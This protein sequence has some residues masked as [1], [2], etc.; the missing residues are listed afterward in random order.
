MPGFTTAS[1]Q[2]SKS[3]K[4]GKYGNWQSGLTYVLLLVIWEGLGRLYPP[5]ILP[6]PWETVQTLYRL[7]EQGPWASRCFTRF[8]GSP[9]GLA[10]PFCAE[11]G[12]A[13]W[14]ERGRRR[15]GW[16]ALLSR[17]CRP[18]LRFRGCCLPF[19]GLA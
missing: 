4:S 1:S 6:G 11:Q 10:L 9:R 5:V 2:S 7:Y 19:S 16:S 12:L 3:S 8:S 18:F 15:T 13:S 17:C 14:Q